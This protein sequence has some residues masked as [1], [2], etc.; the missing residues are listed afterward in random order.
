[1]LL[2][3]NV[4]M[5]VKFVIFSPTIGTWSM[6]LI[7]LL[8]EKVMFILRA[9]LHDTTSLPKTFFCFWS[10]G[11]LIIWRFIE[12]KFGI[13]FCV[14]WPFHRPTHYTFFYNKPSL[15]S[16]NKV[17]KMVR[18]SHPLKQNQF[19]LMIFLVCIENS[20]KCSLCSAIS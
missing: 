6:L 13:I 9:I 20:E 8:D 12:V 4:Y 2:I 18:N 16:I 10:H 19:N 7:L 11:C 1:M 17:K 14:H 3:R 15:D 5:I